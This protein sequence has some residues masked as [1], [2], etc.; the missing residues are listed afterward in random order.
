MAKAVFDA[1]PD[2]YDKWF[3]TRIGRLVKAYESDMLVTLLNPQPGEIILD[4]GCGTGIFTRDV[5]ASGAGIIGMDL[6][7]PML[8]GAVEK[9]DLQK[10]YPVCADMCRLPFADRSFDRV[11]SMTAIEFIKN[12]LPCID[13]LNR[14]TRKGGT[15]VV[16]T[17]NSLS[18]WADRRKKKADTGHDLFERI[19]FRSPDELKQLIPSHAVVKSAIHFLKTD[20]VSTARLKEENGQKEQSRNG[21]FLA[22]KWRKM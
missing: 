19:Y 18:P 9:L 11:F 4:A 3:E 13:E 10:F 8:K 16:T 7:G 22:V 14:V 15:I 6:S 12:A 21:A 17:L 2:R 1:W 5:L 20:E